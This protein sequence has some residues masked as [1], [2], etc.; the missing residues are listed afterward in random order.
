[1]GI[2]VT[3][4]N[5]CRRRLVPQAAAKAASLPGTALGDIKGVKE[6]ADEK[7]PSDCEP[8]LFLCREDALKRRVKACAIFPC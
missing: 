8:S 7:Q 2:F 1:M 6:E 5:F 3:D 4:G